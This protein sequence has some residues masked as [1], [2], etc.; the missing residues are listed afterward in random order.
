[1]S[2]Q[3]DTHTRNDRVTRPGA[4]FIWWCLPLGFGF[5]ANFLALPARGIAI[6][7]ATSFVWMGTGCILNARRC[8]RLHCYI[9]GPVFLLGAAA[10][11]LLAAGFL[12]FGLHAP[13][14]IV[15]VTLVVAL[16]SFVPEIWKK[17]A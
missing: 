13:N 17:Y 1:V 11:G 2:T 6:I 10:L 4:G 8:H 5:A 15:G 16:L 9:S 12:G 7:W 3:P 14:N